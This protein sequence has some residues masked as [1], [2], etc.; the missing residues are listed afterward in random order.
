MHQKMGS[1]WC[2]GTAFDNWPEASTEELRCGPRALCDPLY[3]SAALRVLSLSHSSHWSLSFYPYFV[4]SKLAFAST[5][6]K[7]T[8]ITLH[9]PSFQNTAGG[10]GP[11]EQ[12]AQGTAGL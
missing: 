10:K 9:N 5:H 4:V 7:A 8:S 3:R 11:L 2:L 6:P 1:R 12:P